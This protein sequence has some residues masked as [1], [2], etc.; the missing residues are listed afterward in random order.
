MHPLNFLSD[1]WRQ[2]AFV[3]IKKILPENSS[4]TRARLV[5]GT[6]WSLLGTVVTRSITILLSFLLARILGRD[7]FG[8]YGIINNTAV[9]IGGFAGLGLG[10]TVTRYVANLRMREPERAGKIIGLSAIITWLSAVVYGGIFVFFAPY[11]ANKTLAAPHLS[12]LLQISSITIA[13]GVVNSVQTAIL[14]GLEE[15]KASSLLSTIVSVFQSVL[16]VVLAYFWGIKGAIIALSIS[17]AISVIAFNVLSRKK[18][19][20]FKIRI[21]LKHAT[22]EWRVLLKYSLPSFLSTI[23]VGPV[24]WISNTFL[25]NQPNGYGQLGVFNA[26]MQWDTFLKFFPGLLASVILPIMSGM[27]GQGDRDGSVKVM[28]KMMRVTGIIIVPLALIVS[29][30]SPYIIKAYGSSFTGGHWVIVITATTTIFS[31]IAV[32]LGTF[33][34]ASGRMWYGF[35]LNAIWGSFFLGLSYYMVSWGAEGL[36]GARLLSYI[37]HLI[38]SLILAR[39]ISKRSIYQY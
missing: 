22:S 17:S 39:N 11:L 12:L 13:L 32:H 14:S 28:W 6:L 7:G 20:N 33:I 1:Y 31:S 21:T 37:T 35:A 8:E 27:Y 3:F 24:F 15:F 10:S 29:V 25:A 2:C 19:Y 5:K 9:M 16:V 36:A 18:L 34:M 30:F 38:L 4:D 26:A 23:T